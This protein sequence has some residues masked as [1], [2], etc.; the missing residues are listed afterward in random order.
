[1]DHF[2]FKAPPALPPSTINAPPALL[3]TYYGSDYASAVKALTLTASAS[4]VDQPALSAKMDTSSTTSVF[5]K[6]YFQSASITTKM[7][8]HVYLALQATLCSTLSAGVFQS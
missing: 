8:V 4:V 7:E 1:V 3:I 5:V 2:A 6:H